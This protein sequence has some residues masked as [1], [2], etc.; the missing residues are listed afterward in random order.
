[1]KIPIL[2]F[3]IKTVN[4][5]GRRFRGFGRWMAKMNPKLSETLRKIGLDIEPSAFMVGSF[6]SSLTYGVMIFLIGTLALLAKGD[7]EQL[8]LP[9]LMGI[10]FWIM[11]FFLHMMY[12]SI[13]MKKIAAKESKD[14]LFA[15]REIMM[16]VNSGVPLFDAMKNVASANYGYV[17]RDFQ[18]VVTKI[19]RGVPQREA[20]RALALKSESEHLKRAVWQM[21]NALETGASMSSALPGIV[22]ALES[23]LFREIKNYS[24]NLN[25]LLLIYMLVAAVVPSLG[26]TFLVLLSAFSELGVD[27]ATVLT[28]VVGSGVMQIAMI[29]YMSSTRPEI[30]GG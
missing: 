21:V 16:S 22:D 12:P 25:F 17:S 5:L 9:V 7:T 20:L 13:I 18:A 24:S 14:M 28:L 1:M 30:F 6:F 8:I 4:R 23:F 10:V 29:G 15:L 19:E 11:F 2:L 3:S 26:I 27:M